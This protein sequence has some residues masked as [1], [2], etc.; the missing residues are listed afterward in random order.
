MTIKNKIKDFIILVANFGCNYSL[1]DIMRNPQYLS[2]QISRFEQLTKYFPYFRFEQFWEN[3]IQQLKEYKDLSILNELF[4]N[5]SDDV[6]FLISKL[7][8]Y[9]SGYTN[10]ITKMI[11]D[12][13]KNTPNID[14]RYWT[15][16]DISRFTFH[17][18]NGFYP[19]YYLDR[20]ELSKQICNDL[21]IVKP[22]KKNERSNKLCIVTVLFNGDIRNST[23]RVV[24][25]LYEGLR[26]EFD[27]ICIFPLDIF[28]PI[29]SERRELTT[30][31]PYRP[32]IESK[33]EIEALLPE[34]VTIH[35][36]EGGNKEEKLQS[37]LDSI[38]TYNPCA[39]MDI[40]DEYS[41]IS[42]FYSQ[43]F[44]TVYLPLRDTNSSMFYNATVG[45]SKWKYAESNQ[46]YNS[47]DM[48]SVKEWIFP[49]YIPPKTHR[50]NRKNMLIPEEAFLMVTIGNNSTTFTKDFI[51]KI[52]LL[53]ERKKY[54]WLLVGQEAPEYMK[55]TYKNL[56]E[57]RLIIET[58]YQ[59][60]LYSLCSICDVHVRP[61]MTGGSG[62]T[63][64]AA[65]AGL[66]IAMTNFLCDASRWLGNE[67]HS[68][69]STYEDL[70]DYIIKLRENEEFYNSEKNKALS[71]VNDVIETPQK[72]KALADILKGE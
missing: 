62:A 4:K 22:K 32:S 51:D 5:E 63:A 57:D 12:F 41:V 61:N 46:K 58:G 7:L 20:R 33:K 23:S 45:A 27:E 17:L 47:V 30:I 60:E 9:I 70:V 48:N 16:M 59:K 24:M 2:Y 3:I 50:H 72:W 64:I 34:G 25:M 13:A 21:K 37:I 40:S 35:F 44:Y 29:G 68:E 36:P 1:D 49:E 18:Q 38:Y 10:E 8:Y 71:L 42:Y 54:I 31:L 14:Y 26:S 43:D 11:I 69:I 6:K 15:T 65:M 55:T 66:P 28:S 19:R 39:I 52:C 53:I 67:Y 56:Y